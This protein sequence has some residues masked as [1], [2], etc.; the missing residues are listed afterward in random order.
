[1]E[2]LNRELLEHLA[3]PPCTVSVVASPTLSQ[4]PRVRWAV[5]LRLAPDVEIPFLALPDALVD[6]L[7][8]A[9]RTR[10]FRARENHVPVKHC[11]LFSDYVGYDELCSRIKNRS[12]E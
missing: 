11:V 4:I 7:L 2:A 9:L 10:L 12:C 3:E 6:A 5:Y 8:E 1:M